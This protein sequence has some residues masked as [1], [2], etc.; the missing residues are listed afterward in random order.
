[1]RA[2]VFKF[3]IHL[4]RVEVNC[5]KANHD[6]EIYFALFFFFFFTLFSFFSIHL[7]NVVHRE[8]WFKDFSGPFAPRVLKFGTNIGYSH[9]YYVRENQHP[10]AYHSIYLSIFLFLQ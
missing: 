5:V 6:A 9:L 2:K 1:M 3:C 7:S 8:I 10:Y 4:H